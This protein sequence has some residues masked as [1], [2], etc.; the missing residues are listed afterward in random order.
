ML[1]TIRRVRTWLRAT[2]ADDQQF[3][4]NPSSTGPKNGTF[5]NIT[6]RRRDR[7]VRTGG[8]CPRCTFHLRSNYK[9]MEKTLGLEPSSVDTPVICTMSVRLDLTFF[10][11]YFISL[12][13]V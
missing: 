4:G 7:N 2:M 5:N 10:R 9:V 11:F 8:N 6:W 1:S 13:F 12:D 3:S